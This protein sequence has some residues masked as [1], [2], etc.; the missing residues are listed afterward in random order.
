MEEPRK[1][2]NLIVLLTFLMAVVIGIIYYFTGEAGRST[3]E[4]GIL[5][6]GIAKKGWPYV[7]FIR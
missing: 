1:I 7:S 4:Q 5:I 3:V 2:I 6:A